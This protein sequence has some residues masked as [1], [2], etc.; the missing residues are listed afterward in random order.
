MFR[1]TWQQE[2]QAASEAW[3]PSYVFVYGTLKRYGA[4]NDCLLR[5]GGRYCGESEI[6]GIELFLLP[7]GF[8][9][10]VYDRNG[11]SAIAKGEI[12]RVERLHELDQLEGNG[13][14]YW[15]IKQRFPLGDEMVSAWIYI[16]LFPIDQFAMPLVSGVYPVSADDPYCNEVGNLMAEWVTMLGYRTEYGYTGID[17]YLLDD[18][19]CWEWCEECPYEQL[20][21]ECKYREGA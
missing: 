18:P 17:E 2:Q 20:G 7:A 1:P 6:T 4:A 8:P 12:W 5:S 15:R 9:A 13:R 10:A 11:G 16:Y 3:E 19:T 21:V 14:H